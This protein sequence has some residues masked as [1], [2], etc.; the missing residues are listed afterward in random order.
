MIDES[1]AAASELVSAR[2]VMGFSHGGLPGSPRFGPNQ[3]LAAAV[4]TIGR[5]LEERVRELAAAGDAARA[6]VLDAVGSSAAEEVAD[7][8]NRMICEMAAPTDLR[9]ER[10]QSPGY[11]HWDV[12]DQQSIF[13]FLA[14][15][16]IGVSLTSSYMMVPRKSVSYVVPFT[17]PAQDVGPLGTGDAAGDSVAEPVGSRHRCAVCGMSDCPFREDGQEEDDR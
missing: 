15:D 13:R 5:A 12:R 1:F 2:A 10:R 8:V 14:P 3:P 4:C 17:V 11:A 7:R 6:M 16:E 9:P